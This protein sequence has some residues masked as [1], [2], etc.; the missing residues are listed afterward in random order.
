VGPHNIEEL[1]GLYCVADTNRVSMQVPIRNITNISLQAI[2]LLIGRITGSVALHQVSCAQ[3]NCAIQCLNAQVFDWSTTFLECM[4]RQL[5]DCHLW[6]HRN[7]GFGI[8]LWSFFFERVPI[9]SP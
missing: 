7:F 6:T 8:I 3:M 1:I 5:I 9:F 2:V 4:K